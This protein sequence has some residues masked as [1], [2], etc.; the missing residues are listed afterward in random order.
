V[1]RESFEARAVLY[2]CRAAPAL[3]LSLSLCF[4]VPAFPLDIGCFAKR[5]SA[6]RAG[7]DPDANTGHF[8][9]QTAP[10]SELS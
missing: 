9:V 1:R 2:P 4:G 7:V 10:S 8:R 5:S 6:S 3:S